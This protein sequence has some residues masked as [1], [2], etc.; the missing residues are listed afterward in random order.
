[1]FKTSIFLLLLFSSFVCRTKEATVR[2]NDLSSKD[3]HIHVELF[4]EGFVS[5]FLNELNASFSPDEN[6]FLYTIANNSCSNTFYSIFVSLKKNG[7]WSP[8]RIAPFSGQFSDADPFFSPDGKKVY[9]ISYRPVRTNETLNTDSDIWSVDYHDG[10]WSTPQHLG[11]TV[12]SDADEYYPSLSKN[13]NLY[14]SSENG[15]NGYD[16]MFSKYTDTGFL[17]AEVIGD[18]VN[19]TATEYDAY[20]APDESYIIF[21]SIGRKDGLGSG[22]LYIS[23]KINGKWTEGKNLGPKI[24]STFMDQCPNVTTDGKYFFFTSFRDNH[25]FGFTRRLSTAEYINHLQS[26]FNGMGNIF[27]IDSKAIFTE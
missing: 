5:T 1:M 16:I 3:P 25:S 15:E 18:S 24:N 2:N 11:E 14:F 9:F 12:N 17:K 4:E 6:M 22:D 26:P 19:T 8:P 23:N 7:K 20:I 10:K 13:G 27:W 21:T